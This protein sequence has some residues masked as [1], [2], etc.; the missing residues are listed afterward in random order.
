[1]SLGGNWRGIQNNRGT[2][3]NSYSNASTNP[4]WL[5]DAPND[6]RNTALA[7]QILRVGSGFENSYE[8][9]YDTLVGTVP[10]TTQQYNYSVT[11]PTSGH[12]LCRRLFH[13]PAFQSQRV[14][15]LRAGCL[16]HQAQPD[17]DLRLPAHASPGALRNQR[18]ADFA[19][20]GHARVVPRARP[21]AA[22][23]N[24]FE[25]AAL[26]CTQRQGQSSPGYWAKQRT[27]IAPRLSIVYAPDAH[28]TIRAGAGMYFDHFGQGIVNYLRSGRLLRPEQ[29]DQHPAWQL[30]RPRIAALHRPARHS[31]LAGCPNPSAT[32]TYPFTADSN[33]AIPVRC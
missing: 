16:A 11:S 30:H 25:D 15:V 17:S 2:D 13:Q 22:Q 5:Y 7:H 32:I 9:A 31:A 26:F 33:S 8:I 24:V 14:R 27:N 12:A 10:E 20:C 6:S 3:A 28:T 21:A 4:Y 18:P 29:L 1:M 19:H 23:G